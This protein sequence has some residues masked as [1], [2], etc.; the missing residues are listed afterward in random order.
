M[1][2]SIE[3]RIMPSGDGRWYWELIAQRHIIVRRG[4]A[5]T[6]P[7]ACEQAGEAAREAKLFDHLVGAQQE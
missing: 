5:D 4:L 7:A 1:Q 6:E 3:F 2:A